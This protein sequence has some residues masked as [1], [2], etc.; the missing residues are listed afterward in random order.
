MEIF[1]QPPVDPLNPVD[2]ISQHLITVE[3]S[4][5]KVDEMWKKVWS[6]Q[7]GHVTSSDKAEDTKSK[8][9]TEPVGM[10]VA[11]VHTSPGKVRRVN[12]VGVVSKKNS[13]KF[14]ELEEEA[15]EVKGVWS[16]GRVWSLEQHGRVLVGVVSIK[17]PRAC[18]DL[19]VMASCCY[20]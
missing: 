11:Q 5:K 3:H 14:S 8:A 1:S 6:T 4:K 9:S 12:Q 7:D 16:L 17:E 18:Y 2:T 13:D 15:Y 10:T 20:V 19:L